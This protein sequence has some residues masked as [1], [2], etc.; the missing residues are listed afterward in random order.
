ML[1][2]ND[3]SILEEAQRLTN[4]ARQADYGHPLDDYTRTANLIN[5][6]FSH[7][8]AQ[9][10][11]AEDAAQIQM[12]VKLS[13]HQNVRKRDN[14]VDSAGYAW[15]TW[16]C[17]EERKRREN[18]LAD[19]MDYARLRALVTPE[20]ARRWL[21]EEPTPGDESDAG[22]AP[23]GTELLTPMEFQSRLS[24]AAKEMV[25]DADP[26]KTPRGRLLTCGCYG[27]C[28]GHAA[29]AAPSVQNV[30]PCGCFGSCKGL[31]PVCPTYR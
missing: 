14:M 15:V 30:L 13:R 8:L 25:R 16:E 24:T 4:G 5:A 21:N 27:M 2:P 23:V 19:P 6:L 29:I 26:V 12:L 18:D 17:T 3:E 7:K 28:S 22:I 9:P 11:D 20:E 31:V 1:K 10:F